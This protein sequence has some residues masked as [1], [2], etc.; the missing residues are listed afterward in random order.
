MRVA[1]SFSSRAPR[2]ASATYPGLA[3]HRDQDEARRC[4]TSVRGTLW[5][6]CR[7]TKRS[8]SFASVASAID[9]PEASC[10]QL[11][12][13]AR[14]SVARLMGLRLPP[15]GAD[16]R[17]LAPAPG[18]RATWCDLSRPGW[19]GPQHDGA[20][21]AAGTPR[22]RLDPICRMRS[23]G[24]GHHAVVRDC[25]TSK[26]SDPVEGRLVRQ[27]PVGRL[28]PHLGIEIHRARTCGD[29]RTRVVVVVAASRTEPLLLSRWM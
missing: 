16:R 8:R 18:E 11:A 25:P 15:A 26:A 3:P 6:A 19:Q 23:R 1:C 13:R 28:E 5:C 21:R 7:C 10:R 24:G 9:R 22:S 4:F 29:D 27:T 12:V 20:R 2:T 17:D 14:D